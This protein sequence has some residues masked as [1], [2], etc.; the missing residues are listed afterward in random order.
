MEYF[1][2]NDPNLSFKD[3]LQR[4]L[5]GE[6][7]SEKKADKVK[8]EKAKVE[9]KKSKKS[10]SPKEKEKRPLKD[11]D[12]EVKKEEEE[13]KM[14]VDEE[15]NEKETEQQQQKRKKK[16]NEEETKDKKDEDVEMKE[17]K[18]EAKEEKEKEK[19]KEK[20]KEKKEEKKD[21]KEKEKK[22]EKKDEKEKEKKDEFE[23]DKKVENEKEKKEERE[24]E[25]EREKDKEREKR[26]RREDEKSMPAPMKTP[27]RRKVCVSI[28]PPQISLHQM[29]QMITSGGKYDV[30]L[31]NDLMAQT[32]AAAIKWPKDVILQVRLEH[33]MKHVETGSWPVQKNY[34]LGDHLLTSSRTAS[35]DRE[36]ATPMSEVSEMSFDEVTVTRAS[37]VR[38]RRG[39]HD[40]PSVDHSPKIRSLL[41]SG[42]SP[43][44][45]PPKNPIALNL[46]QFLLESSQQTLAER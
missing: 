31:M 38:R 44:V 13:E 29:E 28:Q 26:K 30:E 12:K 24:K 9:E 41:T 1:I 46:D 3:V 39:R 14:E 36:A 34:P 23:K 21:E 18:N 10:D 16:E 25:K 20:E 35:P 32:Y 40:E 27:E 37:P 42:A 19:N 22:E 6:P 5:C 2:L 33:V 4:H 11:E 43:S 15:K 45:I 8:E 7:L 17:E